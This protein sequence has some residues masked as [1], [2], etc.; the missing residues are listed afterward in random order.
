MMGFVNVVEKLL[1]DEGEAE[2]ALQQLASYRSGTGIFGKPSIQG[3]AER[4]PAHE[5]WQTAGA[6]AP[7]LQKV[8]IRVLAQPVSACACERNWSTFSFIHNKR[9]NRLTQKRA[10]ALVYVFSN[11]RILKKVTAVDYE[12]QFPMW[13]SS[14][15]EE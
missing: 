12:E 8:A 9:R 13:P 10:S 4:V 7:E 15:D 2:M 5:W 3:L 14:D 6:C 11:L 1:T